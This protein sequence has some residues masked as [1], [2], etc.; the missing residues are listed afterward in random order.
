MGS[1]VIDLGDWRQLG[2]F[3]AKLILCKLCFR[4]SDLTA[5]KTKR[6]FSV[7]FTRNR[8]ELIMA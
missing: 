1:I 2:L 4:I 8:K 7:S 6:M 3:Y 5:E